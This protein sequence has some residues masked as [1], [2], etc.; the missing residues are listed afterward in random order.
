MS[1]FS[2]Y[3]RLERKCLKVIFTIVVSELLSVKF[4]LVR[5]A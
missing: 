1:Y 2:N 4:E 3:S 5:R